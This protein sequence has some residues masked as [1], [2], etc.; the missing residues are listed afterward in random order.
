M[1]LVTFTHDGATR[2]G[3]LQGDMVVD[4]NAA[5]PALPTDMV[6]LLKGGDDL[7]QQARDASAASS[8][9]L[10]VSSIHLEAPI[11]S[12]PRILA[13]GLNYLAHYHELPED[14]RAKR[15]PKPPE[16]PVV[17]NKQPTTVTGPYDPIFLPPESDEL[18]FEAELAVV[19]GKTCRRVPK[20]RA[21]EVIAGYTVLNDVTIRD[22]QR[23][24]PTMT[25]GKSFD[26][27]CPM[28][29]ALLTKDEIAD[30][31]NLSVKTIVDGEVRQDF[32]TNDM[33]FNIAHVI[34]YLSTAF[35]LLPGDVIATG[36]SAGV[37]LWAP[38]QPWMKEGQVCRVEIEGLGAIENRVVK[39]EAVCI[40]R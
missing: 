10:P 32:N 34:N 18:D 23:A 3:D 20:D 11:M 17:F 9:K 40:I 19:I 16:T 39:E 22:W 38:G 36:T 37:A 35:T 25:V 1:K 13:V 4:L 6:A 15:F 30:P 5:G 12:P 21:V 33:I 27:H 8:A 28:G 7:M 26:S 29:P 2:I 14:I 31:E 24:A